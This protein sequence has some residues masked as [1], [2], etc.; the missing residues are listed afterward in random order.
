MEQHITSSDKI[1]VQILLEVARAQGLRH[2]V[3]SPGSR[4][5]PLAVAFDEHPDFECTVIHDERSAAFFALGM[6][7]ELGEPVAIA[8]TSGSALLNY[9]PAIAEAYY[10]AVPLIVLSA[11][12][13]QE[14]TDQGDGQTIVQHEALRNH[15]RFQYSFNEVQPEDT[16]A[17]WLVERELQHGFSIAK[18]KWKG[19]VHFNFHFR[20]PLYATTQFKPRSLEALRY[21]AGSGTLD[22]RTEQDILHAWE[23][24]SK[25]LILCGQ[26]EPDSAL[27]EKL[28]LL[29]QDTS[30]VVLVENTSNLV[31]GDFIHCIDRTLNG[32]DLEDLDFQPDMLVTMGGAVVSK[33]IK[34]FL[35]KSNVRYH[36]RVGAEFP[37]MDTYRHLTH[38][39]EC[40]P[41]SLVETLLATKDRN[42]NTYGSRWKQVDF[43]NQE[44]ALE[45]LSALPYSD[46]KA[47]EMILDYIPEQSHVHFANSSVIRYAQLFDPV[48]SIIYRGNRGTSGIDGSLSTAAGAA[49]AA[50]DY[51]HVAITGDISFIYDSN[52]LWNNY[53][54]PNLRIILIN[55]G[56]GDIFNIIPGPG[57]TA[58][59]QKFFVTENRF[60]AEH[61]CRAFNIGYA[62][63][64]N[65]DEV[66]QVMQH[67]YDYDPEGRPQLLEIDTQAEKNHEI[68][69]RYFRE[70][71]ER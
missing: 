45:I 22:T 53:L 34:A 21:F 19:P 29:A 61:L 24:T 32:M 39:L 36:L 50:K 40:D 47:F 25:R 43:L 55:N 46:M 2:V 20:E 63:A 27:N 58:Q 70:M 37:F 60:S 26:M 10:Q 59:R 5:A 33:R 31:S 6:A 68:L 71:A 57:S 38:A 44:K 54:A 28:A 35:R 12:R 42:K 67:F 9:Y 56:G 65:L 16:D 30:V 13:P 3:F 15:I 49:F 51:L 62:R 69:A 66:D 8:C 23:S 64:Q 41:V 4:N 18:G 48:K 17:R 7:L 1:S 52:A 14:W 11:D